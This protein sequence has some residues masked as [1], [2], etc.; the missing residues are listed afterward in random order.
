MMK[1]NGHQPI[2]PVPIHRDKAVGVGAE[3]G[4]VRSSEEQGGVDLLALSPEIRAL[5]KALSRD[6]ARE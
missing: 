3:V 4:G 1:E 6:S 5:L 2:E